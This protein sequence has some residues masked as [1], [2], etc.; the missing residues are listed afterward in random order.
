M[1]HET[2]GTKLGGRV[3]FLTEVPQA[4]EVHLFEDQPDVLDVPQVASLLGVVPATVRREI[5]RGALAC[6]HVGTR[7]KVT[8]TALLR[9][10]GEVSA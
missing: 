9:Y 1:T 2:Q 5:A 7:V 10:V 8:K 6:I 3:V 4:N